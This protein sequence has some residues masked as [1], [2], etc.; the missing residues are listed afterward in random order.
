M[1]IFNEVKIAG[2]YVFNNKE[3]RIILEL[4]DTD[5]LSSVKVDIPYSKLVKAVDTF[6]GKIPE[7]F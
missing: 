7:N 4:L 1:L 5:K 2:S 6:E 3:P